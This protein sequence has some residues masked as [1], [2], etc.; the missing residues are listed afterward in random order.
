MLFGY[1]Q[2]LLPW[3]GSPVNALGQ[4]HWPSVVYALYHRGEECE[5]TETGSPCT[6]HPLIPN[7]ITCLLPPACRW[8]LRRAWVWSGGQVI[9]S[10]QSSP[11]HSLKLVILSQI[12]YLHWWCALYDL[13]WLCTRRLVY[14]F[15]TLN[16]YYNRSSPVSISIA[17]KPCTIQSNIYISSIW[18]TYCHSEE[19]G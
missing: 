9:A 5:S 4:G 12:N 16:A 17:T 13:A 7:S 10:T 18:R 6:Q 14:L 11:V 15:S 19:I 3:T 1:R 8:R 2:P